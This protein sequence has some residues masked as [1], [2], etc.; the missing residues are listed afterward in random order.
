MAQ[1]INDPLGFVFV[2]F[3]L[4]WSSRFLPIILAFTAKKLG[5]SPKEMEE[6]EAATDGDSED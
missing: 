3:L 5:V 4:A 2:G 1:V 6:Y